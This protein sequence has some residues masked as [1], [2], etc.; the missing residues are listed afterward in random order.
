MPELLRHRRALTVGRMTGG[1]HTPH[2]PVHHAETLVSYLR[3]GSAVLDIGGTVRVTPGCFVLLPAG[4]PHQAVER[5]E[6]D[7]W[8]AFC[9]PSC[10]GLSDHVL[11]EPFRQVRGGASPVARVDEARQQ[12][13]ED[14]FAHLNEEAA[15]PGPEARAV[16]E[17]LLRVVLGECSRAWSGRDAG[18]G[19]TLAGRAL[20]HIQAHALGPLSLREVA[21]AVHCTPSHLASVVKRETGHTVGEW[22]ATIR[23]SAAADWLVHSD[24]S[25]SEIAEKV[26]WADATHFIRQFRKREG[27]TPAVY[28]RRSRGPG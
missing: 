27:C 28:R 9:C 15:R 22:I 8:G 24:A 7:L 21:A 11:M 4:V 16:A 25:V 12:R 14:L 19:D 13:V 18:L 20:Q 5:V 10:L 1:P 26:G 17:S 6:V 2:G 3:A 23:V